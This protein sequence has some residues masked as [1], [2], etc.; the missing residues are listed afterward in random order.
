[1]IEMFL[2][3][4]DLFFVM[5]ET[6]PNLGTTDLV[7]LQAWTLHDDKAHSDRLLNC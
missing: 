1:M 7:A 5:N 2:K 6:N 4:N 3:K